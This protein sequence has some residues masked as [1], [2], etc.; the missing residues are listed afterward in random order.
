[1]SATAY[2]AETVDSTV[3]SIRDLTV[4][5]DGAP[6]NVVDGVSFSVN[7]GKTLAIVGESGCGKSVTSMGLMGLLPATAKVGASDSLLIDEALLGM[8]EDRLLDVRGNRMAMIFQE[9][10]TSL[11]PVFTIG[12][13]IAE[14]V[15]RH[16][17]LSDKAARQRALDM[18]EKVRVPD[19][20]QRLDAYPHELSGGMRQRAMIAMAL[21]N[22]PALIIADE[23]TTALDVTI[24][25][26]ILS[27]I[28]NLQTETGTAMILI[29]HDLG[30]VAEV[31]DDVMVMYAGRVV[32]SGPVKT[33][34]DDPQHP[35]TIGLMGSMPSIGPR[36]G[37]LATI[38]GRVPTPAEMPAGCRFA[39]RCPFVIQQCRDERPP[40][41]ELSPGH[42]A[43]CIRAPLEQHV[44]VSA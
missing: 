7:R 9:P 29:T 24:Q 22:D 34:F 37:R 19:A 40:L 25:A 42:F 30:V 23:P 33:L 21:A 32:E 1:M 35:Y 43:A 44:G 12:E 27:L 10:M 14:S 8:S 38:N 16:Q 20:R 11:N 18:L 41:L 2:P 26:Q 15:M 5:F 31:A 6:A 39:G 3:L 36:E 13:Q 28:A 17:G 4:R